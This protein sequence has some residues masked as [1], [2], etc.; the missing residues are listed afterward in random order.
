MLYV[1]IAQYIVIVTYHYV[2]QHHN[3]VTCQC[4][5][6]LYIVIVTYYYVMHGNMQLQTLSQYNCA[7]HSNSNMANEE[8]T[9]QANDGCDD[10]PFTQ[11]IEWI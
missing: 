10:Q 9:Y 11:T 1:F 8:M 2:L 7:I 6:A 5:N 4:S 3:V